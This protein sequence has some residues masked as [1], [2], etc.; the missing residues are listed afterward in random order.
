MKKE[1][2]Q[3]NSRYKQLYTAEQVKIIDRILTYAEDKH[4]G[5]KRLSGEP[6][7]I[8]PVA[9]ANLL[10]DL[11]ID[12]YQVVGAALLHDV[13]EDTSVTEA[14]LKAEFGEEITELVKSVTKLAKITFASQEE[15]QAEN[16]RKMFFAM[17]K[18][19]RVILIKIADRLHNM[20]TIE[21]LPNERQ[22]V[23]AH[24]TLDIYAPLASRLGMSYIKCELEDSCLKTLQP[25]QYAELAKSLPLKRN[26]RREQVAAICGILEEMLKESGIKGEVSGR[27]KHFYSIYKKMLKYGRTIDQ[28]YD[29]TAVRVIVES[30]NDCYGALGLIH[31]KWKPI[32]GRFKDFI[33][34]PKPNNYQS[35]HTTV[36][37]RFGMPFEIQ[38]RTHEMHKI[39]E[40][41]V[42]AHW[43][44]K[45]GQKSGSDLDDKLSWLRGAAEDSENLTD[46]RELYENIKVDFYGDQ[47]FIFTPKG[48]VV[49]LPKGATTLDFAY[50]VH[51]AVGN[52]CV[53]AKINNKIVPLETKLNNGDYVEILTSANSKGPSRDWLRFVKSSQAKSKIRSF[54]KKE[55]KDDNIKRGKEMLETEAKKLGYNWSALLVPKW[56][57]VIMERYVISN[58]DDMYAAVGYGGFTVNQ[59]LLKLVDFYRKEQ[60]AK[61]IKI[62]PRARKR[63][64]A[65]VRVKGF[66]DG[67]LIKLARCCSPVPG[68]PIVGYVSRGRGVSVHRKS[69]PNLKGSEVVRLIDTEWDGEETR[70][71]FG[72]GLKIRAVTTNNLLVKITTVVSQL[73]LGVESINARKGK[74]DETVIDMTVTVHKMA[75]VDNLIK[76]IEG[77]EEVHKVYRT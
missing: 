56:L 34:V 5:Q 65:G 53:G 8:H 42:A 22:I 25:V 26:E 74:I 3:L 4:T 29:L 32:P 77:V 39:A 10:I 51:S 73:K 14:E 6:Y 46:A 47:V 24:E 33:A 48:D 12:D 64:Q 62:T 11:G 28:L 30:V 9:V 63:S 54:F 17:A 36:M 59:I 37:T 31:E 68:D 23:F 75:D 27:P 16:F 40:Y 52:K 21:A 45:E 67:M 76:K 70:G 58:M 61:E 71:G 38:I 7:I 72:V 20:R 15:E 57:D 55:A 18:D 41:G 60:E 1:A 69:C 35:L 44:Y 19:I 50:S 13:L 49:I 2:E 66:D 43:K